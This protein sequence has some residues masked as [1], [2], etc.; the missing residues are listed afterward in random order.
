MCIQERSR[1]T[2]HMETVRY[3]HVMHIVSE[4]EG[5]LAHGL[6]ALDA[7]KACLPAGTVTGSPKPGAME[8]IDE[9]EDIASWHLRRCDWLYRI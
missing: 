1:V 6:H 5:T 2:K 4:V 8:I 9:L 7:L 3:E